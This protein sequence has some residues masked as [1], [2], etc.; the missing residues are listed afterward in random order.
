MRTAKLMLNYKGQKAAEITV[1]TKFT[2]S[3]QIPKVPSHGGVSGVS[4]KSKLL[5]PDDLL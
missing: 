3:L 2:E 5:S 1:Q 4:Q